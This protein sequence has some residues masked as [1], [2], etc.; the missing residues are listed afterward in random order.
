MCGTAVKEKA[1]IINI[2]EAIDRHVPADLR[3]RVRASLM[4][5]QFGLHHNEGPTLRSHLEL[6]FSVLGGVR[7]GIFHR[8]VPEEIRQILRDAAKRYEHLLIPYVFLHDVE[9]QNCMMFVYP[10]GETKYPMSLAQWLIIVNEW[11][12]RDDVEFGRR[13]RAFCMERGIGQISYYQERDGTV[14]HHG[15][16]AAKFLAGHREVDSLI[17]R[18][19]GMHEVAFQFGERGGINIPLFEETF[20]L[21][22]ADGFGYT[23]TEAE[24]GF[25]L[26]VNYADQMGSLGRNGM[27]DISDFLWLARTYLAAH[28][29]ADLLDR[30]YDEMRLDA[31]RVKRLT[32]ALRVSTSA[33]SSETVED[34]L[35]RIVEECTII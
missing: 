29:Y 35:M 14:H 5:P 27:P 10:D 28:K 4:T 22:N 3:Q 23:W 20:A 26:L 34:A 33:F 21:V 1:V 15:S 17:V 7:D 11:G 30:L 19:V 13:L 32:E 16:E 31:H 9:K 24:L 8:D 18:A 6:M 12:C 2:F 25:V